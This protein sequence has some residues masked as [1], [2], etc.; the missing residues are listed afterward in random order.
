MGPYFLLSWTIAWK[1][2]SPNNN[3]IE[4]D[5]ND[6][7]ILGVITTKSIVLGKKMNQYVNP[8]MSDAKYGSYD[9]ALHLGKVHFSSEDIRKYIRKQRLLF[10]NIK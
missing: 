3:T 8:D 1:N 7:Q 9:Q 10:W 6:F 2:E 4:R 5:T